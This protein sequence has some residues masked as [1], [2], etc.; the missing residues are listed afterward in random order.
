MYCPSC[1]TDTEDAKFCPNCGEN[2]KTELNPDEDTIKSQS[3]EDNGFTSKYSVTEF[4]R[5][6]M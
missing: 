2:I 4:V 5:S 1:G 6:T 3:Y